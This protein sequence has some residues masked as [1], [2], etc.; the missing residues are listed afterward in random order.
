[1][2]SPR[3]T[4]LC[5]HTVKGTWM[6]GRGS[7]GHNVTP[8]SL[9]SQVVV[10]G[11]EPAPRLGAGSVRALG[12]PTAP[13][14]GTQPLGV[15]LQ[16]PRL[17][18]LDGVALVQRWVCSERRLDAGARPLQFKNCCGY[19]LRV[20]QIEGEHEKRFRNFRFLVTEVSSTALRL[21]PSSL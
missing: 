21:P 12:Q 3:S 17:Q 11:G 9:P 16:P 2:I 14:T 7:S 8:P 6:N 10:S 4:A 15:R 18:T 19:D 1:M 20:D 13:G 5:K